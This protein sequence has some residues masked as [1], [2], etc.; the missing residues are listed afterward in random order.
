MAKQLLEA[1]GVKHKTDEYAGEINYI[2]INVDSC[3][4]RQRA[5]VIEQIVDVFGR[6][7]EGSFSFDYSTGS[8]F[9][10]HAQ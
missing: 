5:L 4:R 2:V 9:L 10:K 7:K 8:M 3:I 6:M 1:L